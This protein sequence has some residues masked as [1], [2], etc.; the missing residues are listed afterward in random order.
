MAAT[1]A[2]PTA[3][4]SFQS[5][6]GPPLVAGCAGP[7]SGRAVLGDFEG[8]AIG[9]EHVEHGA[10]LERLRALDAGVP[11]CAAIAHA[12]KARAGVDPLLE[13][14]WHAGVDRPHL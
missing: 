5:M 2:S 9:R 13:A 10:R 3:I 11:T 8:V 14:R 7:C 6:D 1:T 4:A 12:R